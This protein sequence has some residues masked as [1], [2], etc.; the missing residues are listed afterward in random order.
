[1]LNGDKEDYI[2]IG[3][4]FNLK[5]KSNLRI[6]G[7]NFVKNNKDKCKI[8]FENQV[9]D[10]P[11]FMVTIYPQQEISIRFK[12]CGINN[13]TNFSS[14][15]EGCDSFIIIDFLYNNNNSENNTNNSNQLCSIYTNIPKINY[16]NS[17]EINN[18]DQTNFMKLPYKVN[19]ISR[20]FYGCK[21]LIS[22]PDLS[23]FFFF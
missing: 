2:E 19:N 1:M 6:F 21:S 22:L 17:N 12:L 20:M 14:M 9:H 8:I 18:I 5:N 3:I 23:V 15:F 11:E 7:S 16:S 4:T 10:L 13:I